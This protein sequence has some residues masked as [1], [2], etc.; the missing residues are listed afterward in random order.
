MGQ[1][2]ALFEQA[3]ARNQ[4][5]PEQPPAR[6]RAV[7]DPQPPPPPG[8][9]QRHSFTQDQ[10]RILLGLSDELPSVTPSGALESSIAA[11]RSAQVVAG[12][13]AS[14]P[15]KAYRD[16]PTGREEVTRP[17]ILLE[18]HRDL[19]P[20][21]WEELIIVHLGTWGNA[22][23]AMELDQADRPRYLD[24]IPPWNVT[25]RRVEPTQSNPQ[26]KEFDCTIQ[27]TEAKTVTKTL[28]PREMLHI[29]GFG[30]N[31]LYGLSPIGAARNGISA[32]IAAD[33]YSARL[34]RKGGLQTVVLTVPDDIDDE[35][36]GKLKRAWV[37]DNAGLEK[38]FEPAVVGNGATFEAISINPKDAQFLEARQFT[39]AEVAGLYGLNP[40]LSRPEPAVFLR[41]LMPYLLRIEQRLSRLLP[42]GQFAEHTTA[43]YLRADLP[44]RVGAYAVMLQNGVY[45]VNEVR[46]FE[47]L[48]GIGPAGDVYERL[49]ERTGT[50]NA[51]PV[52]G[53][54]E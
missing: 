16:T 9:P 52:P 28:T 33:E 26:G 22:Y 45:N 47:N 41:T 23:L 42:R 15:L 37:R 35:Q 18:P 53:P 12:D 19:T 36:A 32:G 3:V 51:H 2:F 38:A 14:L 49:P 34:W 29:P 1:D 54:R 43:G 44:T 7:P 40:D 48:E 6:L 20:F 8:P 21:E 17:L 10:V 24:P 27:V 11:F 50:P 30:Y 39:T 25:P 46:S 31:G 5:S 4:P 13:A